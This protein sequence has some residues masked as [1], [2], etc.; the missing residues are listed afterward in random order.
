ML[1]LKIFVQVQTF[2]RRPFVLSHNFCHP[3]PAPRGSRD[4]PKQWFCTLKPKGEARG[5]RAKSLFRQISRSEGGVFSN[6]SRLSVYW[7]SFF[8]AG[9]IENYTL[10]GW[11]VLT[12]S[13]SIH[14]PM[15]KEWIY[16][17]GLDRQTFFCCELENV[18][19]LFFSYLLSLILLE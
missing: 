5:P 7:H 18:F 6:S 15:E 11:S 13:N 1:G 12:A 14:S 10:N 9:G 19:A 8:R 3:V 16:L 17:C 2:R 4:L